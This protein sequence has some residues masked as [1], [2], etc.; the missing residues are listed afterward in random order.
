MYKIKK[1]SSTLKFIYLFF[2]ASALLAD[3]APKQW[4]E[5][6]T[7]VIK[8]F[9]TTKKEIALTFDACGGSVQS[10]QYDAQLIKFLSDNHIPATLFINLRWIDS[11]PKI[12]LELASSPNFEIANHGSRHKPLSMNAKAAY[13]IIGTSSKAE[14]IEEIDENSRKIFALTGKKPTFFRAGTAHYDEQAVEIA[15]SSGVKVI[16]FSVLGDAGAS[17]D[18]L[19]VA[20]QIKSAHAGDITIAHMNHPESGTREGFIEAINALRKEGF[21][22]VRLSDIKDSLVRLP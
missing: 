5:S 11:N 1:Q 21:I 9:N 19:K 20:Q 8:S 4:G 2:M 10:S 3:S 18:A 17:Y 13:G 16:G 12:F 14:I 15:L 22:F 6:V 7:G